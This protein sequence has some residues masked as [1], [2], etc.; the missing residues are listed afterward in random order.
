MTV[1]RAAIGA[2][3]LCWALAGCTTPADEETGVCIGEATLEQFKAGKTRETW[4]RAVIGEP[5]S[6]ATVEDDP[7]LSVLRYSTTQKTDQSF[8]DK[9]MGIP[10]ERTVGTI[11]FIVRDGVV[12]HFW[13][14]GLEDW[15][16]F[17]GAR[18][19]GEKKD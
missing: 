3:L 14:D 4:L 6:T 19:S 16:M 1:P 5:T 13:A 18:D 12:E 9:L 15:R 8:F 10:G 7:G 2:C 11:Y 17:G